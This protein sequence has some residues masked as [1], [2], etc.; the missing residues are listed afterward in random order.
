MKPVTRKSSIG[1]TPTLSEG[2]L[3]KGIFTM[4]WPML[5]IMF[6]NFM[7]GFTDIYVA[8]LLGSQIQ[9][10]VGFIEQLYFLLILLANAISTG[11][12]AIVSRTAG[13]HDMARVRESSRQSLGFGLIIALFFTCA[14]LFLPGLVVSAAGF[15]KEIFYIAVV[16]LRIFSVSLGFN[17]FLIISNAILRALGTPQKPLVS[18]G[19]YAALNVCL[20]FALVFGWGPIPSLGYA[21]IA[22][23]TTISVMV[24]TTINIFFLIHLGWPSLFSSLLRLTRAYIRRLIAVSWPMALV[25]I[26]WNAGTVV[27]YNILGHLPQGH[28]QAMAAYANG[29]RIEAVI[30]MP[31]FALNMAASVLVG[32]NLG[33]KQEDRA[34]RVGWRIGLTGALALAG[35]AAPLYIFAPEVAAILTKDSLVL[36]ETV[37]YLHYNLLATPFMALSLSLGGGLQGAGDTRGVM[38]AILVAMW[39]IRLPL[40]Y[41]LGITLAWG[42][43][44]VWLA[45]IFSMMVQGTLMSLRFHLGKWK[46]IQV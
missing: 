13:S 25:M 42:A 10:A 12:V 43:R 38:S 3:W 36:K 32:Q 28:I 11:S 31:A 45:M 41:L 15:P 40:A 16:F 1:P 26:A 27:L 20:D 9:A 29:L 34:V 14:G 6:F 5:L 46:G 23:S 24:A 22:V 19:L 35:F 30:F 8:G 4:S 33:A 17:Y 18:M 37:A 2:S 7:V 21:G 39:M 44:G